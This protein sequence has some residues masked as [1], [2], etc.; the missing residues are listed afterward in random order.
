[1]LTFQSEREA[2][3][4]FIFRTN[5]VSSTLSFASMRRVASRIVTAQCAAR[6]SFRAYV[7]TNIA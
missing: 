5:R 1:M 2:S 3:I 7:K 4:M 6:L